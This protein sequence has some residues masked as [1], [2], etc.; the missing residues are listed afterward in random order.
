M[1][2]A[3]GGQRRNMDD[4]P[5]SPWSG[6]AARAR[7]PPAMIDDTATRFGQGPGARSAPLHVI[8]RTW[9]RPKDH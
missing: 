5:P 9:A 2:A 8:A 3:D 7:P 6:R 1:T 4:P